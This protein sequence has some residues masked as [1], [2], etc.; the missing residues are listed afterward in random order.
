MSVRK[1]WMEMLCLLV[2]VLLSSSLVFGQSISGSIVGSV[3]DSTD[4][5]VVGADVTLIQ[6]ATGAQRKTQT[7]AQGDFVFSTLSP[8]EYS[9]KV[10]VSG[11]K[12]LTKT[13]INLSAA[14][15]LPVGNLALQVGDVTESVTVEARGAV[16]QTV[17]AERS[18]TI[19]STQVDQIAIRGR[20]TLS[21]LQLLPGVVFNSEVDSI[22]R[23]W[24]I[25]VNGNRTNTLGVSLDGIPTNDMGAMT[26]MRIVVSQDAIAEV[27][28]LLSNYQ[29]EY[30][31]V[32]GAN[33][34]LI[35]KSGT[36]SFHGGVSYYKRHEQFNAND[37]FNN[38]V[39]AAKPR[40]RYNTFNYNVGGPI[41]V[42]GKFNANKEK[43]FFFWNQE[44][45]PMKSATALQ[46][47]TVPTGLERI[48]DFSQSVDLNNKLIVI[49]DPTTGKPFPGN[50]IPVNRVNPN[51][52]A[53]MSV[54]PLPNF[55]DRSISGGKYNYIYQGENEEPKRTS[56]LKVDYNINSNNIFS[57]TFA[58]NSA[59]N[60][61]PFVDHD[62]RWPLIYGERH[63]TGKTLMTSYK[64]IFSPTLINELNV[65][66]ISSPEAQKNYERTLPAIQR[67]KVG[68]KVSQ[69][70]PKANPLNLLPEATFGGV[71]G[72]AQI[73]Y[74]GRFPQ[75]N[76]QHL[77]NINDNITKVFVS[78]ALKAGFHYDFNR[79]PMT[80][81][82]DSVPT[83]N[84][85]FGRNVNNPLDTGYAYSNA[86]LGVFDT[87][88]ETTSFTSV[89]WRM[90]NIEWFL[91]DSWK[92]TRRLTLDVGM[93]LMLVVPMY[94][95]D[96]FLTGFVPSRWDPAKTVQLIQP[97][98]VGGK[99]VGI[100]PVTG[101]IYPVNLIGYIASNTGNPVNG[102]VSP[103]D[104]PN[105]PRGLINN[106]GLQY[107]P[108]LG[109]A[110]DVAG[111]GKTAVR[112]GF[113]MFYNRQGIATGTRD[114]PFQPPLVQTPMI[115]FGTFETFLNS[116]GFIS[117]QN[118]LGVDT[119]GKLP[120]VYNWS[121]TVQK[122]VGFGTVVDVGYVGS[123][124]RHLLWQRNLNVVLAGANFDAKNIDP[125]TNK[126]FPAPFLVPYTGYNNVNY[127]EYASS[128]NYHSL[129]VTANRRFARGLQFGAAWT[130]S[131]SMDYNSGDN[132]TVSSLVPVRIWNYGL[133]DFD[134]T[135]ILKFNWLWDVPRLGV[136][137]KVLDR[138]V[139]HWQLSGIA[140]FVS[141]NPMSV[142][143]STTTAVDITGT[144]TQGARIIVLD[145]PVLP[146]SER[147]FDRFFNTD[148]FA[149]PKVGTFGNAARTVIR[150]PGI[151][152]WDIA[153]FKDFPVT[154]RAKFQ[155]RLETYNTFN[156]TQFSGL[157][158]GARFDPKTGEQVNTR[159][160]KLTGARSPRIMQLALRFLF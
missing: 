6:R 75:W 92:A 110:W 128:S 39:G 119:I 123:V 89:E 4:A 8:G 23:G 157:D 7:D 69:F 106:R 30:G 57:A 150:G 143:W 79:R 38:Q 109:F 141:G 37:Y 5:A 125:T 111:N 67:D 13:G 9:I 35:T 31:R 24:D 104:D 122:D 129:Q 101:E 15:R 139:N 54:F 130:W 1:V 114:F 135:H 32:S 115:N 40:Y 68:F 154:E 47:I 126:A 140:S 64:R 82:G 61:S 52:K 97:T 124:G 60:K 90:R 118:V 153:V 85:D 71:Q 20:N 63:N 29:A 25:N 107:A 16:V 3:V 87:Y 94:E 98:I 18:G 145:N 155:F 144:P 76:E 43:L 88:R 151:N 105:F 117:A 121:L 72:A 49:N 84:F 132:N 146:K 149:L 147:T 152:N 148:V 81:T 142:G 108:R 99:R 73:G 34:H 116:E 44:F 41:Y 10:Q 103:L 160:G 134:R 50:V 28:V 55:F 83:G 80:G 56:T 22:D 51:G 91:Q 100:H 2:A 133:S 102:M 93:R 77:F 120:T 21:L 78:H 48:G 127:R 36:Q 14:E 112:G 70:N 136:S 66:Y 158:T 86:M 137:N 19:T 46:R 17:S 65:G 27:K 53:L 138:V 95:R 45:W 156:H 33:V 42:P 74:D 113:G 59:V 58:E 62:I 96:N 131:K 11:F 12:T 159:F 26:N